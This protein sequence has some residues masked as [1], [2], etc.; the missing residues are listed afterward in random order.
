M[1]ILTGLTTQVSKN[2]DRI[3]FM[4]PYTNF[5]ACGFR[6]SATISLISYSTPQGELS[7]RPTF[8]RG[9]RRKGTIAHEH[10]HNYGVVHANAWWQCLPGFYK[11]PGC[12]PREYGFSND[13]MGWS[14]GGGHLNAVLKR[15]AGWLDHVQEV[16]SSGTYT[17][18]ALEHPTDGIQALDAPRDDRSRFLIEYRSGGSPF[19]DHELLPRQ[20][21]VHYYLTDI[22]YPAS[23]VIHPGSSDEEFGLYAGDKLR[24]EFSGFEIEVLQLTEQQA[25]V[26]ITFFSPTKG[27]VAEYLVED[28]TEHTRSEPQVLEQHNCMAKKRSYEFRYLW[29]Y[30]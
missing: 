6:A 2:Y 16:E 25:E 20:V 14:G 27:V 7:I 19:S 13:V 1:K 3:A 15:G 22:R 11:G 26:E 9:S 21:V 5:N 4:Y 24:D 17:L 28:N 12:A 30:L 18:E 23:F 8:L 29:M 10:M